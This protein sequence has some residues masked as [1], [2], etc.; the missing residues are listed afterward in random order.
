DVS[1]SMADSNKLPLL[2][3]ALQK[4][5]SEQLGEGDRVAIV[6]YADAASV[7]LPSTRCDRKADI[8]AAIDALQA[9]G[10]TNGAAGLQM[11]YDVATNNFIPNG[12]NRVLLCTDGD[13]NVGVSDKG[14]LTRLIEDKARTKVFLSVLGFGQGN[15]QDDKLKALAQHGN[16]NYAYIDGF[17]EAYKVLIQQV[18][19]TLVT[20]AKDVKIQVEFNPA[21]VQSYR[22]IGYEGR[23]M[24]ANEFHDDKKDAGE[25]GA[26]H[27]V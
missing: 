22:L 20:I 4:L 25:I 7:R 3:V 16:G 1:G 17:Q 9:A 6:V 12:T 26:G 11:A 18:G 2:K 19:A 5:V 27:S 15:F 13:F 24:L 14:S 23:L 8:L 21:K 10:S